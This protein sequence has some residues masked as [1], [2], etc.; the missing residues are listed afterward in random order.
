M[1]AFAPVFAAS[2]LRSSSFLLHAVCP[3]THTIAICPA[4]R[5]RPVVRAAV[6]DEKHAGANE[7]DEEARPT[8]AK[9]LA[10][11]YGG[12]YLGTSI[13][14]SL[15]SFGVLYAMIAIGV[16]VRG[17]IVGLG[18]WLATTPVGRPQVLE[19]MSESYG[20]FALAYIAHKATSPL[21]FPPTIV[22][23]EFVARRLANIQ[24]THVSESDD[25]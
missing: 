9:E 12:A 24:K 20:T 7:T 21:R 6:V 1:N 22:A 15:V 4:Q 13:A 10:G 19:N 8:S 11:R 16:D 18:D 2:A 3:S 17:G 5:S 25:A 23:T 14:L